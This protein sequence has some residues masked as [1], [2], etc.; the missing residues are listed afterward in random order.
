MKIRPVALVTAAAAGA[1]LLAGCSAGSAPSSAPATANS[2][3]VVDRF[4]QL[5]AFVRGNGAA[6]HTIEVSKQKAYTS[7]AFG[8]DTA[9]LLERAS[10]TGPGLRDLP[11]TL[12][13]PGGVTVKSG[14]SSIAGIGVGGAP[15]GDADAVCAAAGASA[16][17]G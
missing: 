7:A 8:A 11:G 17:A 16:I 12:F 10:G 5:Q 1:L 4:G 2:A 6:E 15:S 9:T 3:A 14:E 13:L